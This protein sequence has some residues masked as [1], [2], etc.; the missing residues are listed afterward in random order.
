[1]WAP[2]EHQPGEVPEGGEWEGHFAAFREHCG[3]NGIAHNMPACHFKKFQ[4]LLKQI[5]VEV[6][7][8]SCPPQRKTGVEH[9]FSQ[10]HPLT[11]CKLRITVKHTSL[12]RKFHP[13][14]KSIPKL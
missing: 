12:L 7:Q 10:E 3:R 8:A 11:P 6:T 1:M 4:L 2:E 5:L 13:G 9:A 14:R